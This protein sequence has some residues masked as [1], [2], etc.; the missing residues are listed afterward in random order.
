MFKKNLDE[1]KKI[2]LKGVVSDYK[3]ELMGGKSLS[4]SQKL[5][6][7]EFQYLPKSSENLTLRFY[8]LAG[9]WEVSS[10]VS[11]VVPGSKG[12]L[13]LLKNHV[14]YICKTDPGII[15]LRGFLENFYYV[16][17][18]FGILRLNNNVI[19]IMMNRIIDPWSFRVISTMRNLLVA[20]K[21]LEEKKKKQ[22]VIGIARAKKRLFL[23]RVCYKAALV[24]NS[25]REYRI[26]D[27]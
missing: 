14:N 27:E 12:E 8:T 23:A 20:R 13:G 1:S 6:A 15:K 24:C 4:M 19:S 11:I 10:I 26:P 17:T 21:K 5:N 25:L 18:D 16:L 2:I 9:S 22:D 7:E 3:Q